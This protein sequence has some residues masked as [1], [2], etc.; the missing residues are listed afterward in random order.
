MKLPAIITTDLHFTSNPADEYRWGLFPWLREQARE[1]KAKSI[2]I[3]G[4]ITD[5]KD[6]HPAVLVNRLVKEITSLTEVVEQVYILAGNHD[7]LKDGHP[8]FSFLSAIPGVKFI[9]TIYSDLEDGLQVL[10][11]PHSKQPARDWEDFKDLSWYSHIFMHQTMRGSL[12]SNGQE[13]GG[14]GVELLK[15]FKPGPDLP[16]IWSGDIHVPQKI[17][18]VEYVGSPYPVH[19]GD[20]FEGRCILV[21]KDGTR[22]DLFFDTIRR[23]SFVVSDINQLFEISE[24]GQVGKGDQVKF[25]VVLPQAEQHEWPRWKTLIEGFCRE[26]KVELHGLKLEVTKP[27]R[28]LTEIKKAT[29]PE[30]IVLRFVEDEGLTAESFEAA[31]EIMR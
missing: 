4:D 3:L 10:W 12:S 24:G 6:Y 20:S 21:R 29:D 9:N 5:A 25:K 30:D 16:T 11:L 17:G 23:P 31:M 13:M 18:L 7:Y 26:H 28:R 2:G 19:F 8:F 27:R 22:K 15:W 1:Y 14:E